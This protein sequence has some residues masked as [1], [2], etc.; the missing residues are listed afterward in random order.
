MTLEVTQAAMP[1]TLRAGGGRR[2]FSRVSGRRLRLLFGD[3]SQRAV[4]HVKVS[5]H[6]HQPGTHAGHVPKA[7]CQCQ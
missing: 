6:S 1:L 4:L 2:R 5:E 3:L 7:R